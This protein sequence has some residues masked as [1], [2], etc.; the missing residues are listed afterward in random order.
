MALP[1]AEAVPLDVERG[2]GDEEE[3]PAVRRAVT[4]VRWLP[5]PTLVGSLLLRFS[6]QR[7]GTICW[8]RASLQVTRVTPLETAVLQLL[9]IH[10]TKRWQKE[11]YHDPIIKECLGFRPP[12]AS[13]S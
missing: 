4:G 5:F 6:E 3:T 9:S 10:V 11:V 12:L 7:R 13:P 1:D 2:M 8:G